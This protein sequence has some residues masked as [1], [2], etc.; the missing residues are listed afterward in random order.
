MRPSLW[1]FTIW[2]W[3]SKSHFSSIKSLS[4]SCKLFGL[5]LLSLLAL[6]QELWVS[7][8]MRQRFIVGRNLSFWTCLYR[9][10]NMTYLTDGSRFKLM[11]LVIKVLTTCMSKQ[12]LLALI[13]FKIKLWR[14]I[15]QKLHRLNYLQLRQTS[16]YLFWIKNSR[17]PK[18]S[19]LPCR[20]LSVLEI[21]QWKLLWHRDLNG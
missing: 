17:W 10:F 19:L 21:S 15:F 14:S 8:M 13:L 6:Q 16:H 1:L 9:G 5:H 4:H 2:R 12:K 18:G 3:A 7:I 11:H 20:L